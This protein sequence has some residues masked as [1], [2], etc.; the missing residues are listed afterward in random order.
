M[1]LVL[2]VTNRF[3]SHVDYMIDKFNQHGVEF[4]RFNTDDYPLIDQVEINLGLGGFSPSLVVYGREVI[5]SQITSVWLRRPMKFRVSSEL[6]DPQVRE[7]AQDE[8]KAFI[9]GLWLALSDLKW[10]S[11]IDNI[12][13]WQHKI[14]QLRLAQDMGFTI[15][16]S[17]ITT[18]PDSFMQFWNECHGQVIF[19]A[20]GT[21][22]IKQPDGMMRTAY[23]NKLDVSFLENLDA[24]KLAPCLF[25]EYVSK[26]LE[27]RVTVVDTQVFVCEIH[28]QQSD[29]TMI[30][31]RHYDIENTPHLPGKL[32]EKLERLCVD[33]VAHMG[34]RYGAIDMIVTP[35]DEYV[36]VEINPNGQWLWLEQLTGLPIGDALFD[37]L[38]K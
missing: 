3:D 20:L 34:L 10:V 9:D 30:D 15:P 14:P 31:W 11:P 16:Q 28:S 37:L 23:T 5:P 8:C 13:R 25:Q 38:T 4:I 21:N 29:K 19:K 22:M 2:V 36:F 7:Y 33:L 18:S 26:K 35:D 24:I 17:L 12:R 32:P 6:T 27:L 1:S